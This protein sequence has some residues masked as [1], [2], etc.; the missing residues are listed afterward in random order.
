MSEKPQSLKKLTIFANEDQ[1]SYDAWFD[2]TPL[3]ESLVVIGKLDSQESL[4]TIE[5]Q[6]PTPEAAQLTL[7]KHDA[8]ARYRKPHRS[9]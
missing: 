9:D 3:L 1:V 8:P 2:H 5:L 7:G 4:P 6:E